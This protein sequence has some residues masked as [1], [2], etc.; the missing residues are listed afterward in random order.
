M[1]LVLSFH[2]MVVVIVVKLHRRGLDPLSFS[3]FANVTN[4]TIWNIWFAQILNIPAGLIVRNFKSTT[5]WRNSNWFYFWNILF[6]IAFLECNSPTALTIIIHCNKYISLIAHILYLNEI[7]AAYHTTIAHPSLISNL[8]TYSHVTESKL[9]QFRRY[10][11]QSLIYF[12][13][14]TFPGICTSCYIILRK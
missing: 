13:N 11:I 5:K 10:L 9:T 12:S 8:N 7:I 2:R 14:L 4:L 1:L 3:E 6:V